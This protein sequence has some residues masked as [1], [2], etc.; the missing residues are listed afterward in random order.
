MHFSV[1]TDMVMERS[2][3]PLRKWVIAIYLLSSARKGM[4]SIALHNALGVTP[5]TAWYMKQ[6][7]REGWD[8]GTAP[9]GGPVGID[10]LYV[11]G[12]EKNKH[13]KKKLRAGRGSVG[14]VL[15]AGVQQRGGAVLALPVADVKRETLTEFVL[16][17]VGKGATV[18]TDEHSGYTEP[19][20][21][22]STIPRG[23]T[24][25]TGPPWTT[26]KKPRGRPVKNKLKLIDAPQRDCPGTRPDGRTKRGGTQT[27]KSL[28]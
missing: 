26:E 22:Y 16:G 17:T 19:G 15:V 5:K 10:G 6:R 12:K 27:A 28:T 20:R 2:K 4:S 13:G 23:A 1:G 11:G 7:I 3:V 9:L 8:F 21:L 18:Y 14:K 24:M 25:D